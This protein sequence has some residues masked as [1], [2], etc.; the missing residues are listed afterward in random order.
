MEKEDHRR[1][2]MAFMFIDLVNYSSDIF[3]NPSTLI[4][5]TCSI[6]VHLNLVEVLNIKH[7]KPSKRYCF[8]TLWTPFINSCVSLHVAPVTPNGEAL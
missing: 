7:A 3:R 4:T 5:L 2:S 8:I 1:H 6:V